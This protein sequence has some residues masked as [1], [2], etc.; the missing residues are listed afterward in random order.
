MDDLVYGGLWRFAMVCLFSSLLLWASMECVYFVAIV[1]IN[2]NV[3]LIIVM[4]IFGLV[5]KLFIDKIC[6]VALALATPLYTTCPL[7]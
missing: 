1:L 5:S 6:E 7:K 2:L 3:I 4:G